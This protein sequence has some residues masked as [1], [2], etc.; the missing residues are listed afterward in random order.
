MTRYVDPHKKVAS[1]SFTLSHKT[2]PRIIFKIYLNE[3]LITQADSGVLWYEDTRNTKLPASHINSTT[4]KAKNIDVTILH[5]SPTIL[6]NHV[7]PKRLLFQ[8][9]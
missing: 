3:L 9:I 5:Q 7:N 6:V 1:P 2:F 8:Y 4:A